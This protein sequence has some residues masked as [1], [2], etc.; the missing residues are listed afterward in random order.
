MLNKIIWTERYSGNDKPD[1]LGRWARVG[2]LEHKS[3]DFVKR[4]EIA[5]IKK[6]KEKYCAY[7]YLGSGKFSNIHNKEEQAK[8][9]CEQVINDFKENYMF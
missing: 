3:K 8:K 2:Y 1:D 6:V 5:W 9:Y 7:V 4:T